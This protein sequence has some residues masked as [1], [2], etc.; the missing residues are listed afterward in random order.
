MSVTSKQGFF[1]SRF[2]GP[3]ISHVFQRKNTGDELMQAA[4]FAARF[5]QEHNIVAITDAS[6]L[7]LLIRVIRDLQSEQSDSVDDR[8]FPTTKLSHV[9]VAPV[10]EFQAFV[11]CLDLPKK[12]ATRSV[13]YGYCN[14]DLLEQLL[15]TPDQL[16]AHLARWRSDCLLDADSSSKLFAALPDLPSFRGAY[17]EAVQAMHSREEARAIMIG[18]C[19]RE[20]VLGSAYKRGILRTEKWRRRWFSVFRGVLR[21]REG[22]KERGCCTLSN[23]VIIQAQP[24][25]YGGLADQRYCFDLYVEV[26][27]KRVFLIGVDTEMELTRWKHAVA[28]H[29]QFCADM[30]QSVATL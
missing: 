4:L 7:E 18:F 6:A 2:L 14:L 11:R 19:I 27:H 5:A 30:P 23:A 22:G 29:R 26:P 8:D 1:V 12:V 24:G 3:L 25:A 28:M 9:T 15:S 10:Q 17:A 16:D 21:Y 20:E 13:E